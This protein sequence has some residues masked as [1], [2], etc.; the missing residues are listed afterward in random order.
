[1]TLQETSMQSL[2][3]LIRL[4]LMSLAALPCLFMLNGCIVHDREVV[5]EP[6]E[7][8][9]D[10][11]HHRYYHEHAWVVCEDRDPHCPPA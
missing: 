6:T 8:Y 10:A 11:P 4:S 1:M 7:G 5:H 2:R 9:Y 3:P